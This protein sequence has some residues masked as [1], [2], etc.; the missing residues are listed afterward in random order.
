[1]DGCGFMC[2]LQDVQKNHANPMFGNKDEEGSI[3]RLLSMGQSCT[4]YP[5]IQLTTNDISGCILSRAVAVAVGR[6]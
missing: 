6:R 1:M 4:K 5:G 2:S 3:P